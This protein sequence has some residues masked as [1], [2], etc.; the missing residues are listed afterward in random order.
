MRK[1]IM[2]GIAAMVAAALLLTAALPAFAADDPADGQS[3]IVI[4]T[5][6]KTGEDVSI[7]NA[8]IEIIGKAEGETSLRIT[9]DGKAAG[10]AA[11]AAD[12]SFTAKVGSFALSFGENEVTLVLQAESPLSR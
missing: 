11:V 5:P 1:K 7:G 3:P 9:V 6:G 8:G 12:G 10:T 4:Y 2:N